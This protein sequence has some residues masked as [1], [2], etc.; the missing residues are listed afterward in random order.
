[1]FGYYKGKPYRPAALHCVVGLGSYN[2]FIFRKSIAHFVLCTGILG[3][4]P[5]PCY[6]AWSLDIP[7][8]KIK[9]IT[10]LVLTPSHM[11][12]LEFIVLT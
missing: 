11:T 8:I 2:R 5:I 7:N 4:K 1:M 9:L 10:V 3:G 12:D 6:T